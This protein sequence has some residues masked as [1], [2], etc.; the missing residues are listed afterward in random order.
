M[1]LYGTRTRI[2]KA[3]TSAAMEIAS[4]VFTKRDAEGKVI[5]H[6]GKTSPWTHY[7]I[8]QHPVEA[9]YTTDDKHPGPPFHTGGPFANIK[10][11]HPSHKVF[12][13]GSFSSLP[14]QWGEVLTYV[15]GFCPNIISGFLSG[16][17]P[18]ASSNPYFKPLDLLTDNSALRP[19]VYNALRP[20]L[21]T[22]GLGVAL[23]EARDLPRM[24]RTTAQGFHSIWTGL[25]GNHRHVSMR[26]KGAA[27]Q[28]LNAQFG[29]APFVKDVHAT[30]DTYISSRRYIDRIKS[31]NGKW[32]TRRR[33]YQDS[34]VYDATQRVASYAVEPLLPSDFYTA[35]PLPDNLGSGY[36]YYEVRTQVKKRTWAEGQFTYYRPE[37]DDSG[38]NSYDSSVNA[39]KRQML[40]YGLR[41]NPSTIYRAT[42]WTWLIDWFTNVGDVVQRATDWGVDAIV[43][44]YMYLM[45]HYV[46]DVSYKQILN[47]N[48]GPITIEWSEKLE[49]KQRDE[50][51]TPFGFDLKPLDLSDRQIAILA[52]LGI[53]R[54][55]VI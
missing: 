49:T 47:L 50:A 8:P 43:S 6:F 21:E 16:I 29:W 22:A 23:A 27:N 52:A 39:V 37:F 45:T 36:Y 19:G 54:R 28:F 35:R 30:I 34:T 33:T 24:M 46:I 32:S 20:R 55:R 51:A 12:G 41:I 9:E 25:G 5:G 38:V 40:L 15:G 48:A 18:N 53:S 4:G 13:H 7:V 1:S 42:P 11:L 10:I 2:R 17:I 26:P 14:N 44:K 3:P 31:R